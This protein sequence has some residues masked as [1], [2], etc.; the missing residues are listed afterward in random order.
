MP[1]GM[2]WELKHKQFALTKRLFP[3]YQGPIPQSL[4]SLSKIAWLERRSIQKLVAPS[5]RSHRLYICIYIYTGKMLKIFAAAMAKS[6]RA[7]HGRRR[8]ERRLATKR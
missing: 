3:Q 6:G 5:R 1:P 4:N 2:A 7:E 8:R